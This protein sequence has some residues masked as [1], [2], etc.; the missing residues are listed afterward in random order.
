M[1]VAD[2]LAREAAI[3]KIQV[4]PGAALPPTTLADVVEQIQ[5]GVEIGGVN[6]IGIG[7]DFD[8]VGCVPH[9]LN[10]YSK[11]PALTRALL[12]KGL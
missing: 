5:H 7:T 12:E 8:G 3:E 6:H 10:S 11:F 1:Q 2:P 9:D 4:E